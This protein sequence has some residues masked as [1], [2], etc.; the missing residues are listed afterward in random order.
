MGGG[1][2]AANR[3]AGGGIIMDGI[4][5]FGLLLL[6]GVLI[7]RSSKA[8]AGMTDATVSI[9]NIR[10]G[11]ARGWYTAE[12]TY[13]DGKPAVRLSGTATDGQYTSDVYPIALKDWQTLKEEGYNVAA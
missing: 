6:G 4:I 2:S 8:T 1:T 7:S 11:V 3:N 12:L 5:I 13:A 10:K 9:D